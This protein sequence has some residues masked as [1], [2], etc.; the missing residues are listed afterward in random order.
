MSLLAKVIFLTRRGRSAYFLIAVLLILAT[1]VYAFSG[2]SIMDGLL[3]SAAA[4]AEIGEDGGPDG[5]EDTQGADS[6]DSPDSPRTVLV[7]V[8]TVPTAQMAH[9]HKDSE[10]ARWRLFSILLRGC[11]HKLR[12]RATDRTTGSSPSRW[13]VTLSSTPL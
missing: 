3:P 8:R 1:F 12:V 6:P 11:S 13:R 9:D 10:A 4:S 7:I 5:P 2:T